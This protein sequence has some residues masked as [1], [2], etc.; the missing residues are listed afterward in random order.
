MHKSFYDAITEF[1]FVEDEPERSDVIFIPGG[2]HCEL[3]E[4]AAEL[5]RLGYAKYV[6]PSGKYSIVKGCMGE[7]KSGADKY[8]EEYET[9]SDFY[10]DVLTRNKVPREVIIEEKEATFTDQNAKFSRRLL[11]EKGIKVKK[12]ILCCKGFHARRSLMYYERAFPEAEILVVPA[13]LAYPDIQKDN[14]YKSEEG[15]KRVIGEIERIG[16][17][18]FM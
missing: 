13:T 6:V 11:D 16:K 18:Y 14:W 3:P 7:L 17:Q 4:K 2:K 8:K 12:A 10:T 5:Y 9:E 1:I 15:K